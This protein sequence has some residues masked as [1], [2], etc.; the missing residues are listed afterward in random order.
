MKNHLV[1]ILVLAAALLIA[2]FLEAY[3]GAYFLKKA[4]ESFT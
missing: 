4:L 2:S 1:L 3:P